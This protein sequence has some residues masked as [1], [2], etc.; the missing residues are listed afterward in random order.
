MDEL[1]MVRELLGEPAPPR[2]EV[3]ASARARLTGPD[4]SR[5]TRRRRFPV[6]IVAPVGAAAAVTAVAVLLASL[7]HRTAAPDGR[8]TGGPAGAGGLTPARYWVQRGLVGNYLRVGQAG[9]RYVVLES[10]AVQLWTPVSKLASPSISQALSVRPAS[11]ADQRAWRAAGSPTVWNGTGQDTGIASPQGDSDGS[12]R[13]L[14]AGQGTLVTGGVG[15]GIAGFYWFGRQLSVRQLAALTTSPATLKQLL[16]KQYTSEGGGSGGF[17][18]FLISALPPLMALPVSTALRSAMYRVLAD[19]PGVLDL[20]QRS[21]VT[22]QRGVALAV[23][24][25]FS[26]C[27]NQISLNSGSGT[28][29]TFSSCGVQQILIVNPATWLPVAEELRY[30]SLPPGQSWSGPDG[31][32]SYEVFG[33]SYWTRANPPVT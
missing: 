31:L 20:G 25:R 29:A 3:T 14:K 23:D 21:D 16:Y 15:Y 1:R 22:G 6:T 17:G 27:G 2:P 8:V 4:T 30:T 24:G 26:G 7:P 18:S 32:F 33:T 19:L 11:P 13:P 12:L 10:V 28:R 5:R 9:N